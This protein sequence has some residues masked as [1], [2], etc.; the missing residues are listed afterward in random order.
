MEC[1]NRMT[2]AQLTI[3]EFFQ[4][5]TILNSVCTINSKCLEFSHFYKILT[6]LQNCIESWRAGFMALTLQTSYEKEI[7]QNFAGNVFD[8]VNPNV[9]DTTLKLVLPLLCQYFGMF[10]FKTS[11][12]ADAFKGLIKPFVQWKKN[13]C[14]YTYV[15]NDVDQSRLDKLVSVS[16]CT[17]GK[18][19]GYKVT[20]SNPSQPFESLADHILTEETQTQYPFIKNWFDNIRIYIHPTT[21]NLKTIRSLAI[22][23]RCKIIVKNNCIHED[24]HFSEVCNMKADGLMKDFLEKWKVAATQRDV[25]LIE[26]SMKFLLDTEKAALEQTS[27]ELKEQRVNVKQTIGFF[28]LIIFSYNLY[29]I[30]VSVNIISELTVNVRQRLHVTWSVWFES[31]FYWTSMQLLIWMKITKLKSIVRRRHYSR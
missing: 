19:A 31:Q 2:F 23:H 7:S 18:C 20:L 6:Q 8:F 30:L 25:K 10:F 12:A 22:K 14:I 28:S 13:M 21:A 27:Q 17:R 3:D 26:Q 29:K 15:I 1:T 4:R 9:I 5:Q 16:Y 24:G 11:S